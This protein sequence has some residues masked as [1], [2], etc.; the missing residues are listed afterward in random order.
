MIGRTV[1]HYTIE[2]KLGE[3]G[4]GV[5]Y[6]GTDT[7]LHRSVA[8]K[9]LSKSFSLGEQEQRRF[10]REARAASS[11]NHPNVCV[12]HSI[13]EVD[14]E[15]FIVMEYVEGV[16][17]R[18]WM[19]NRRAGIRRNAI[20]VRDILGIVMQVA[21][22]LQAAHRKGIVHRD[23]KPENVMV[24]SEGLVKIMDFG[25]AKT[26]GESKLTRSGA[27]VGTVAYMSPEQVWG[28]AIDV[29]SDIYSFGVLL[30]EL[31]A[32]T[33]PFTSDHAVGIMHAIVYAEPD[34]LDEARPGIDPVLSR[35]VMK[36]MA[37]K[38]EVR[39]ASMDDVI[40]ELGRYEE[41]GRTV[42][43]PAAG[44]R[45]G[46]LRLSLKMILA[47][48]T[49]RRSMWVAAAVAVAGI[50]AGLFLWLPG[51]A[52]GKSSTLGDTLRTV[53]GARDPGVAGSSRG[54][55]LGAGS[56]PPE[57]LEAKSQ[58]RVDTVRMADVQQ[59]EHPNPSGTEGRKAAPIDDV[60]LEVF[61][62]RGSVNPTFKEGDTLKTFVRVNKPCTVRIFYYS[63]DGA[64]YLLTGAEDRRIGVEGVGQAVPILDVIC[65]PPFGTELVHA[66]AR[67]G[68]FGR[69]RTKTEKQ[70]TVL[71]GELGAAL[72]ATRSGGGAE[73]GGKATE[74]RVQITTAPK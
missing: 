64:C 67:T 25:L 65:S 70:L 29:R 3:G 1:S 53:P 35:I 31:L 33:T 68:Q 56:L 36:C 46:M 7:R 2:T 32:G 6:K 4:W 12:V 44:S 34:P 27:A 43:V 60:S 26:M 15:Q 61:T 22:G 28:G 58:K 30:Y 41:G 55:L 23:V 11:V 51:D 54:A 62:N 18:T 73:R 52:G 48:A 39:Y 20:P 17:L 19:A 16:T 37:K 50:L 49:S 72:A 14:D 45:A 10:L 38:K 9:F 69:I 8:L 5:V 63:A 59:P 57:S 74:R 21:H 47:H 40:A 24:E 66:F 71:E 42:T 13:E